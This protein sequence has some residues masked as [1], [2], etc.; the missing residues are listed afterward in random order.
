MNEEYLLKCEDLILSQIYYN[1]LIEELGIKDVGC[2]PGIPNKYLMLRENTEGYFFFD[3]CAEQYF[4][5]EKV[6]VV[7]T[8]E[9]FRKI[10]LTKNIEPDE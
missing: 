2:G 5:I 1:L 6:I 4:N 10:C 7:H 8:F 9:E 3:S